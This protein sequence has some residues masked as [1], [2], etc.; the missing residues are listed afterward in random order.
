M[1]KQPTTDRTTASATLPP[2]LR[3]PPLLQGECSVTGRTAWLLRGVRAILQ[4]HEE[5]ISGVGHHMERSEREHGRIQIK[6]G[7]RNE[8]K[9]MRMSSYQGMRSSL[10]SISGQSLRMSNIRSVRSGPPMTAP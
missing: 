5:R 8:R 1:I 9:P 4:R 6:R 7:L 3:P 10:T 2:L